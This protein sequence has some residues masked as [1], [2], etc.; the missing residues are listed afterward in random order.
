MRFGVIRNAGGRAS[1]DAITSIV[2]LRSLT[3]VKNVIVI[4]HTDC[5]MT[6]LT[7]EGIAKEATARTPAAS[8][9]IKERDFGCFKTEEFE[10]S[11][12]KDVLKLK[13]AKVLEG[14]NVFG[15]TLD[16]PTGVVKELDV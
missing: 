4:H 15:M 16:T 5:G 8:D 9:W 12:K 2:V 11:I 6:H 14:V 1:D 3:N 7:Q 10:E 13:S